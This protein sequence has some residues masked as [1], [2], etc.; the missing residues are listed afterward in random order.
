MTERDAQWD[1]RRGR[2]GAV[3]WRRADETHRYNVLVDVVCWCGLAFRGA[4]SVEMC[5]GLD[6]LRT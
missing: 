6:R 1:H 2:S 5:V 3:G 4:V